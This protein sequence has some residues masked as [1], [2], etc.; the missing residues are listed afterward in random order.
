MSSHPSSSAKGGDAATSPLSLLLQAPS[1]G[2]VTSFLDACYR[3]RTAPAEAAASRHVAAVTAG[4]PAAEAAALVAAGCALV[5]SLLLDSADLLAGA[6]GGG[7]A[8][9]AIAARL[10]AGLEPRLAALLAGALAAALPAW[11]EAAVEGRIGPP[12]LVSS[13]WAVHCVESSTEAPGKGA[14]AGGGGGG[15]VAL[16]GLALADA[17]ARR[18]AL[19]AGERA[20]AVELSPAALATLVDGMRRVRDQLAAV[21]S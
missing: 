13:S 17:P 8:P 7:G 20:V 18:D 19:P 10:P 15:P 2:A 5:S 21:S 14:G 16:L 6:G 12:K 4:L 11:R 3:Y 9:E 1:R